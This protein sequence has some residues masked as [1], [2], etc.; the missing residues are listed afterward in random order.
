MKSEKR[1]VKSEIGMWVVEKCEIGLR[2]GWA[3]LARRDGFDEGS[4]CER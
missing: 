4:G 3:C 1:E 2:G